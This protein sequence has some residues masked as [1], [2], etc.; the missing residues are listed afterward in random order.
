MIKGVNMQ[1]DLDIHNFYEHLVIE[2][3]E[4]NKLSLEFDNEFLADLCCLALSQ[5]P[6]RYIRHDIDMAFY[7][8][9]DERK[10][11]SDQVD[12]AINHALNYLQKQQNSA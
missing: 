7:L 9:A 2:H 6:A 5:L 12:K 8:S 4:T 1:L 3:L 10:S 11:M